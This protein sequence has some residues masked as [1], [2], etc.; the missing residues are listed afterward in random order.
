MRY[1][2]RNPKESILTPRHW[3][4]I[5]GYGLIITLSVI[6]SLL[7]ALKWLQMEEQRAVTVSF[8]TLAFV[9]LWHVFNMRDRD[10]SFLRNDITKNPFIW[11]ALGLCTILLLT[12]VYLPG[13][14]D[15]LNLTHP[16]KEGWVLVLVM[17]GIPFVVGQILK[18]LRSQK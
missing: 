17:S 4:E 11:G 1:S 5:G 2:P 7:I 15:V 8:L 10:S 6:G 3:L 16:G 12:V 13:F 9:Q 14:A 18:F